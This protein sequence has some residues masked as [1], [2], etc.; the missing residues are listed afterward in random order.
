VK[1]LVEVFG[2]DTVVAV[3][4]SLF[5]VNVERGFIALYYVADKVV[6]AGHATHWISDLIECIYNYFRRLLIKH[7][8]EF[9]VQTALVHVCIEV[10]K[11]F[12]LNLDLFELLLSPCRIIEH[13]F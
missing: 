1:D 9:L 8:D 7:C 4:I 3:V 13:G 5:S 2:Q 10:H 11:L 6:H 12:Q